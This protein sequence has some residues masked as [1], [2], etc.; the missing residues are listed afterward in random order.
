M[1]C[2]ALY[3]VVSHPNSFDSC[4]QPGCTRLN[5]LL[6]L[7]SRLCYQQTAQPATARVKLT[8]AMF[9]VRD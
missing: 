9:L 4:T 5:V 8:W 7:S 3:R 1:C 2:H 6:M